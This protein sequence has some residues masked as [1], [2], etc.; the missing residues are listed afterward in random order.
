MIGGHRGISIREEDLVWQENQRNRR[1]WRKNIGLW[2]LI[3]LIN[4]A[5]QV[6]N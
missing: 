4:T 3:L 2:G 1:T 6:I 5:Q